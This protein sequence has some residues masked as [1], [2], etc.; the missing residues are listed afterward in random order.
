MTSLLFLCNIYLYRVEKNSTTLQ[1]ILHNHK[2]HQGKCTFN[3][4]LIHQIIHL[5]FQILLMSATL[6]KANG[7]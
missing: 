7:M 1:I 2:L 4:K 3:K 5:L 6:N